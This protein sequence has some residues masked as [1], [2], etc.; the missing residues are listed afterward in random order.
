MMD[1]GKMLNDPEAM[2]QLIEAHIRSQGFHIVREE[3]DMDTRLA[4]T[5]I[6]TAL[7]HDARHRR[8]PYFVRA[9]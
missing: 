2:R 5:V 4:H 3:P 6:R 1:F 9:G 8:Q 7:L